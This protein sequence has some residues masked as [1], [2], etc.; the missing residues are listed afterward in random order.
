MTRLRGECI[1]LETGSLAADLTGQVRT[2]SAAGDDHLKGK[3]RSRLPT[4]GDEAKICKNSHERLS[5]RR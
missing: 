2:L 5:P 3:F 4:R 1:E